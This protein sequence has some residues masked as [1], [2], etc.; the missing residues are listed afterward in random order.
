MS[1][2]NTAVLV[3]RLVADPIA[4]G[5]NTDNPA[6]SMRIAVQRNKDDV[7]FINV[8]AFRKS[9]EFA[10]QYL[11]KG[12]L[13]SVTG[14]IQTGFYEKDGHKVPTFEIYTDDIRSLDKAP[15]T[16]AGTA[17]YADEDDETDPW[18]DS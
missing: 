4:R 5:K 9:A 10:N 13:V 16:T 15:E 2:V 17:A 18:A 11:T 8:I 14:R 6:S 12:R 3:G 1:A 7:D